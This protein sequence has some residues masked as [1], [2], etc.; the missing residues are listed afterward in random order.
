MVFGAR[1]KPE[2]LWHLRERPR[3]FNELRCLIASVSQKMLAQQLRELE[4]DGIVTRTQYEEIPVRVEYA[5]TDLGRSLYPLFEEI[6][7]WWTNH[8][9][10]V[11]AAR[12][13]SDQK[14]RKRKD[15]VPRV[16]E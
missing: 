3:R 5:T 1:W 16:H 14:T 11:E 15:A 8:D 12:A 9:A 7:Q 6:Y 10:S 13:S 2:I 4:R